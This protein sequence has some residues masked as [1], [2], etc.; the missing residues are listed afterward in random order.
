MPFLSSRSALTCSGAEGRQSRGDH[1][2]HGHLLAEVSGHGELAGNSTEDIGQLGALGREGLE[3]KVGVDREIVGHHLGSEGHPCRVEAES[4][5][6][7]RDRLSRFDDHPSADPSVA[8]DPN[9]AERRLDRPLDLGPGDLDGPRTFLLFDRVEVLGFRIRRV[10]PTG[11]F[12][13]VLGV[14]RLLVLI[15]FLAGLGWPVEPLAIPEVDILGIHAPE[16]DGLEEE[17]DQAD[18]GVGLGNPEIDLVVPG[19]AAE[20]EAAD[21]GEHRADRSLPTAR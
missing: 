13:P 12:R 11:D 15:L 17:P 14:L 4:S 21:P 7:D 16:V 19:L 10:G 2:I 20:L 3:A 6:A 9:T 8:L 1:V 5:P 18:P